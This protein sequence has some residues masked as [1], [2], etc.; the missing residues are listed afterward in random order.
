VDVEVRRS[1]LGSENAAVGIH[2]APN[3]DHVLPD[4]FDVVVAGNRI[5]SDTLPVSDPLLN[6]VVE[7][8]TIE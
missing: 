5:A 1:R 2:I 6:I 3:D 8:N 7:D 4:S